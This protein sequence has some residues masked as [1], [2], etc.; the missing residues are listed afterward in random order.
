MSTSYFKWFLT[1][2][3][4]WQDRSLEET[5]STFEN[6]YYFKVTNFFKILGGDISLQLKLIVSIG[7]SFESK[8]LSSTCHGWCD[9]S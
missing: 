6:N 1:F 2:I 4:S 7:G 8:K 9:L 5:Y 3:I